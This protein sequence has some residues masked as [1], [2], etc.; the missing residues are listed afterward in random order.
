MP[1]WLKSRWRSRAWLAVVPVVL[2][3]LWAWF[4]PPHGIQPDEEVIFFPTRARWDAARECWIMPVHGW[5]FEREQDSARRATALDS[6]AKALK[7]DPRDARTATFRQRARAFLVDNERGKIVSIYL[8]LERFAL[9]ASDSSGHFRH[10]L[11]ISNDVARQLLA[12]QDGE[13]EWLQIEA[14]SSA[15]NRRRFVGHVQFSQSTAP[16]V[17]SDIDDT[18][19]V[20][21]VTNKRELLAN[22]FL[23]PF[24]AAPGMAPLFAR[25]QREGATFHYVSASPWQ[26]YEPLADFLQTFGFPRGE[27]HMRKVRAWDSSFSRLFQSPESYKL[28]EIESLLNA[29]RA[30]KFLLVGDSGERDPE[31]YGDVA[32]RYPDRIQDIWIRNVTNESPNS[33]R[34][35]S[36]FRQVDQNLWQV[37]RDPAELQG[38][39]EFSTP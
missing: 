17:V 31:I 39:E 8:G 2:W 16:C 23:R 27:L 7:L 18:I 33:P 5:I 35:T 4:D 38:L 25:L 15:E 29:F 37:F 21:Q 36:A 12:S 19:K 28:A 11:R 24:R 9:T 1:A 30:Q 3:L 26:L 10:E 32:R 13:S 14:V 34:F 6:L 20:S 22:T